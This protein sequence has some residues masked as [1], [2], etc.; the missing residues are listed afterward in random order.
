[1]FPFYKEIFLQ[2]CTLQVKKDPVIN[3]QN[4]WLDLLD[5]ITKRG[6]MLLSQY[7]TAGGKL[8]LTAVSK[9]NF[10]RNLSLL[11]LA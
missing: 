2:E 3:T 7:Y 11:I 6:Q 10:W 5:E 9:H 4:S 1:M 8:N